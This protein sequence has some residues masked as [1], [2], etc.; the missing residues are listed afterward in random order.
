MPLLAG[1]FWQ[2]EVRLDLVEVA[3][4]VFLFDDVA[5]C[6]Q[7]GDDDVGAAFGDAEAGRAAAQPRSGRGRGTAGP[8]RGW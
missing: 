5:G 7:V 1:G 3:A 4:A 6:G 2:R 8:G